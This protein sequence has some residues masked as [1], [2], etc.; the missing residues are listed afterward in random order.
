MSKTSS[1][2]PALPFLFDKREFYR[3]KEAPSSEHLCSSVPMASVRV[4]ANQLPSHEATAKPILS[5]T[6]P[7]VSSPRS[8]NSASRALFRSAA[9]EDHL[10][11]RVCRHCATEGRETW[12]RRQ[13]GMPS[14]RPQAGC[15]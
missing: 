15:Q 4:A 10:V 11:V 1:T 6:T 5:L 13:L 12:R 8:T 3:S 2:E 7:N 9:T 14:L